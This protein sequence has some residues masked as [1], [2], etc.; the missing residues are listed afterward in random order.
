MTDRAKKERMAIVIN[1]IKHS[2]FQDLLKETE[3]RIMK[4]SQ[5]KICYTLWHPDP[6]YLIRYFLKNC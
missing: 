4:T 5:S 1:W 6:R 2:A 3:N